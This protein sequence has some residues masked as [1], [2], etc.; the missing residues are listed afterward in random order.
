MSSVAHCTDNPAPT[1]SSAGLAAAF[2]SLCS[3]AGAA[4]IRTRKDDL[5]AHVSC[6][7]VITEQQTAA[8]CLQ[9]E[10]EYVLQMW[11]WKC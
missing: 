7:S 4:R 8:K 9:A 5:L 1:R 3:C 6:L 11:Q 10:G 2:C